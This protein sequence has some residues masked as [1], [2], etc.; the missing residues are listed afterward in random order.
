VRAKIREKRLKNNN[1]NGES[2]VAFGPAR[3]PPRETRD[4]RMRTGI[5]HAPAGKK[6]TRPNPERKTST[7]THLGRDITLSEPV[8][9]EGDW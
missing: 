3:T 5:A 2:G 1:N 7:P 4:E 6:A 9:G 8:A